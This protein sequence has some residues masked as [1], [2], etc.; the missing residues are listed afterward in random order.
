MSGHKNEDWK[1]FLPHFAFIALIFL[2]VG[3]LAGS[4][5]VGPL[6]SAT[7]TPTPSNPSPSA[8]NVEE[9]KGSVQDYINAVLLA[10]TGAEGVVTETVEGD[11]AYEFTLDIVQGGS[12]VD[13]VT[14]YASFDGSTLY[15]AAFDLTQPLPSPQPT[16]EPVELEKS[17]TP[18]VELF[19]MSYCL[20]GTQLQKAMLPVWELLSE[21]AD[22]Q[23][24]FVDYTMHGAKEAEENTRQYCVGEEFGEETQIEYLYCFLEDGNHPR[25]VEELSLD[26]D[27]LDECINATHAEFGVDPEQTPYP[28][29][30]EENNLYGVTGSPTFV[31]NGVVLPVGRSPEAVKQ[32]VCEA[33]IEPPEACSEELSETPASTM[34][35]FEGG[36]DSVGQC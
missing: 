36:S 19:V 30:S 15:T 2:G 3:A 13:S 16:Q 33:F 27:A 26:A 4:A 1:K 31:L 5:M 23:L 29:F 21:D 28:I 24:K 22:F 7:A 20:Y 9:L 12:V 32:A 10:G 6:P 34:F 25:C 35:G 14:V 18:S 17:E 8:A 11:S